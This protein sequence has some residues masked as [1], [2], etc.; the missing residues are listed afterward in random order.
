MAMRADRGKLNFSA[1]GVQNR[2]ETSADVSEPQAGVN[3]A[4]STL[5]TT[6]CAF[7]GH[8][9]LVLD[10]LAPQPHISTTFYPPGGPLIRA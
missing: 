1:G 3:P 10:L 4:L 6:C 7:D 8:D 9:Q 5:S 2:F